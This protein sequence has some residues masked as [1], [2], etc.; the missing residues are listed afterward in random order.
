MPTNTFYE[1]A[2]CDTC[3]KA[4]KWLTAHDVKF[5]AIPIVDA[6]PSREE[7]VRFIKKSG[8]PARRWINTSGQSYRALIAKHGKE[9]IESWSDDKLIGELAK[10]GKL[11]KR[12]VLITAQKVL[13][14]FREAE[15]AAEF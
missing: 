4:K 2:A 7:L 11:I 1:Y 15:Y 6:P 8:L 13:V 10:D 14:G 5:T 12:P 3:R 9:A